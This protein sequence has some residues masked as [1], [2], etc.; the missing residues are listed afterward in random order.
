[1]KKS[2]STEQVSELETRSTWCMTVDEFIDTYS[3]G[4]RAYLESGHGTGNDKSHPE[5]LAGGALSYAEVF[6]NV[7]ANTDWYKVTGTTRGTK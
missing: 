1:M 7:Y 2:K 3:K 5:D 4:L 6:Y